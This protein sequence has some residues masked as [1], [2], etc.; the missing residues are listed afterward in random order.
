MFQERKEREIESK[1]RNKTKQSEKKTKIREICET[2]KKE[3]EIRNNID[4]E[5][6][7]TILSRLKK[8][9]ELTFLI[10]FNEHSLN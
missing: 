8:W 10:S 5:I 1:A 9:G 3:N 4:T 7:Y 6:S 2:N